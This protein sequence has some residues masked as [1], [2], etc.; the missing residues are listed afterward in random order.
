MGKN[1]RGIYG[2]KVHNDKSSEMETFLNRIGNYLDVVKYRDTSTKITDAYIGL[3]V[4]LQANSSKEVFSIH[5]GR[6]EELAKEKPKLATQ[7]EGAGMSKK[8]LGDLY[9]PQ[10]GL[11]F[12]PAESD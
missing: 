5:S 8:L 12:I 7:L 6:L 2:I 11:H 3:P 4:S 9:P 10:M 1:I